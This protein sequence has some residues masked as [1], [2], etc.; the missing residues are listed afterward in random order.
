MA[1]KGSEGEAV[2]TVLDVMEI[3]GVLRGKS[4]SITGHLGLP[5]DQVVAIIERAGGTFHKTPT[6]GTT[7]LVTNL[8]WNEGS[9]VA[10]GTSRKLIKAREMGIKIL[11]EKQLHDMITELAEADSK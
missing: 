5:R 3:T 1:R 4:F 2:G 10:S 11:S 7:Y 8:D 6:Y 9:T